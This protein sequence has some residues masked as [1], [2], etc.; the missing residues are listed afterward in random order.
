MTIIQ[1][2]HS[3]TAIQNGFLKSL[4][5]SQS[6]NSHR[7][8][9]FLFTLQWDASKLEVDCFFIIFRNLKRHKPSNNLTSSVAF[10]MVFV[11]LPFPK[12]LY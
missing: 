2:Y 1:T 9:N 11:A 10:I 6:K 7:K 5:R 12:L 8:L 3:D 4:V